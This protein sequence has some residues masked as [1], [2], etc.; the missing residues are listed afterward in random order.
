M[1]PDGR[2]A[3]VLVPIFERDE[4]WW[5]LLTQRTETVGTHQGQIC[6]PG[7]RHEPG[8]ETLAATALRESQEEIGLDPNAVCLLGPLDDHATVFGVRISPYLGLIPAG[9]P[10][11][12]APDEVAAL[13]E[14]P[15]AF[16]ADPANRRIE[17]FPMAGG[18]YR[19]VHFFDRDP[20][21]PVW[22]ATA[23]ILALWF[24]AL[25]ADPGEGRALLETLTGGAGTPLDGDRGEA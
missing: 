8:D 18:G 21:P 2:P 20:D 10:F 11:R 4:A 13:I 23:R 25:A 24:D 1:P 14:L 12:P 22:G 3:A 17:L 19:E 6:F 16:F 9:Y 15:L 5:V 7:G